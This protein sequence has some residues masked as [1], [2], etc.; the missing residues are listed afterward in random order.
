VSEND[1][2]HHAGT[3]KVAV[4]SHGKKRLKATSESRH[5]GCGRDVLGQTIPSTCSS[6]LQGRPDRRRWIAVYV[7]HS[8]TVR[9]QIEGISG[10]R[11]RPRTRAHRRCTTVLSRV[12]TCTQEQ[13][14]PWRF[15]PG[16]LVEERSDAVIPRPREHVWGGRIHDRTGPREY[17]TLKHSYRPNILCHIV[18]S[19][20]LGLIIGIGKQ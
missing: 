11:N 19:V 7:G 3:T 16:Q 15:Q 6:K 1:N 10:P 12:D 17:L 14:A 20:A 5:T 2:C 18:D 9:K 13:Q 4:K 8:A